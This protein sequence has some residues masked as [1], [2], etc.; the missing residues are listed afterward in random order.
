[1]LDAGWG[2]GD[3][4]VRCQVSGGEM[5]DAGWGMR[6]ARCWMLDVY[7]LTPKPVSF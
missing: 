4:G 6:D 5:L 7:F 2:M 3:K 1:M